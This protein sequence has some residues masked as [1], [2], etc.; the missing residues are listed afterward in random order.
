MQ[1][2]TQ[3]GSRRVAAEKN[4]TKLIDNQRSLEMLVTHLEDII[5]R[6]KEEMEEFKHERVRLEHCRDRIEKHATDK[7]KSKIKSSE[8]KPI[9]VGMKELMQKLR[10]NSPECDGISDIIYEIETQEIDEYYDQK[11]KE[12]ESCKK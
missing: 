3:N 4:I 1:K 7:I 11:L 6:L 8:I 10:E 9:V 5:S 2:I 12:K